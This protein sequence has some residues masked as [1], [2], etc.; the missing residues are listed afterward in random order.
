MEKHEHEVAD[1]I[2]NSLVEMWNDNNPKSKLN[3]DLLPLIRNH[4]RYAY[5]AG[6]E[7]LRRQ[8]ED[9]LK[10]QKATKISRY[11]FLARMEFLEL[12]S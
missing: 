8:V 7:K 3:G 4:I 2:L 10:G 11:Y 9:V 5:V 6:W 12:K 1:E